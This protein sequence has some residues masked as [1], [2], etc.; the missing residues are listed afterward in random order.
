MKIYNKIVWD[1]DGNVIEED[2]YDYEGPIVELKGSPPS[3]PPPPPPPP[4]PPPTIQREQSPTRTRALGSM[5]GR[6][7][8]RGRGAL[9]AK[10]GTPLGVEGQASGEARSLIGVIKLIGDKLGVQ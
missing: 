7:R 9:V 5:A 6:K 10:R 3:P 4:A 2:S 1:K 8:A